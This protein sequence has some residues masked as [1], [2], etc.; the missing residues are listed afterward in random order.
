MLGPLVVCCVLLP[1]ARES[2]STLIDLVLA[3][4]RW[5]YKVITDMALARDECPRSQFFQGGAVRGTAPT[6][7]IEPA[8]RSLGE[9]HV[10]E[11][12]VHRRRN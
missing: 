11:L 8:L 10:A 5:P 2:P 9:E 4:N 7:T 12:V 1:I 3:L 6:S